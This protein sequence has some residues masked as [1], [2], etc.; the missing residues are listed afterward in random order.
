[1]QNS[2]AM[3]AI[4]SA[5]SVQVP[6]CFRCSNFMQTVDQGSK[7]AEENSHRRLIVGVKFFSSESDMWHT[8]AA[9]AASEVVFSFLSLAA[10]T[11]S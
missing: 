7:A 8:R 1:M 6:F 9:E 4:Y 11:T 3:R 2:E 5:C 10:Y